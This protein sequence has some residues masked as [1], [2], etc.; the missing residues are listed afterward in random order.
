MSRPLY[1]PVE[2][3]ERL[4]AF[5]TTSRNSNLALIAFVGE[6]L[7]AYGVPYASVLNAEGTKANLFATIGPSI[8]GG[9]VLSGHT[10]VVPVDGQDWTT[11][12]F[13][14]TAR[15][16]RLFGRGT[17]DMKSFPA[18]ALALLPEFLAAGLKRPIHLA[19]SYDEE[20]GCLGAPS[21]VAH[22]LQ[23]GLRP[24]A[25]IVGEPTN[26]TVVNAH[27]GIHSFLTKVTGREAHSSATEQGVSAVM[28]A[29][30]LISALQRIGEDL[31]ERGDP[32]GR[33]DPGYTSVQ[34]NVIHGGTAVNIL[35][36]TCQF[37]WEYRPLP[38]GDEDEVK[39][40]FDAY[41]E[42][43]ALPRLRAIASEALIETV[44]L[45]HVPVLKP[46][47]KSEAE[48]IAFALAES[49][50]AYAVS[51][52]T[53]AGH[54]QNAGLPVVVCGP[55]DIAQAHKPDEFIMASQLVLCAHFMRRLAKR[56]SM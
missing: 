17:A 26:M 1:K 39:R 41:V 15:D 42:T 3:L 28:A 33:F 34:A 50:T 44:Q 46:Q 35:A 9:V 48:T 49:N 21:L 22:I 36:K 29:A 24:S 12:P 47:E 52:A 23:Q 10:D 45:A 27:K 53:E 16:G 40:R 56:L 11:E 25:V 30:D 7:K 6:Y 5:D 14:L 54:F 31:R 38:F 19:L 43:R 8:D 51:Y 18:V 2:M 37:V 20:I 55:G 13:R 32:S 4:V